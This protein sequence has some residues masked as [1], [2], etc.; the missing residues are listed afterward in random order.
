MCGGSSTTVQKTEIPPEVLARYNAVNARAEAVASQ[1][2]QAYTGQFV[3][4]L[5]QTQQAGIAGT[6]AAA[7]AAQPY[8][9]TAAGLTL[10]GAQDVG[11]LT[12]E[13]IAQYQN[14]YIQSVINQP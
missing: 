9:N 2:F 5:S 8:Y 14:P 6:N 3:A 4:P 12:P 13:Q 11:R 1:P 7:N 10:A